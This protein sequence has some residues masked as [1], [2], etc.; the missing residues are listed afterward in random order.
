MLVL[1]LLIALVLLG[2][3]GVSQQQKAR[4]LRERFRPIEDIESYVKSARSSADSALGKARGEADRLLGSARSDA[5]RALGNAQSQAESMLGR[6]RREADELVG[7]AKRERASLND[8]IT[9]LKADAES[10]ANELALVE[11]GVRLKADDAHLLEVGYYEPIYGF[12]DLPQ[13]QREI[14]Q[15][16][17]EQRKMLRTGGEGGDHS[18]AAFASESITYNGSKAEGRKLLKKVLQLML[19]AF[20]GECDSFIARV[21][22]RNVTTMQK[23]VQSSFD[24][25]NKIG[26]TWHC[27]LSEKY[28]SNRMAELNLAYEYAELDQ[29]IKE[30][31]AAIRQQER[32]DEK[33]RREA[34]RRERDAAKKEAAAEQAVKEAQAAMEASS[35]S[36][37]AAYQQRIE[38]LE[39]QLAEAQEERQRAKS[40]AEQTR[41]GYVYVLSN[42]GSF[43]EDV[44]KIGMT[45]REDPDERRRELGDASVPFPFDYHAYI[46]TEDAP[47]LER[48]LHLHFDA[49]RLNLENQRKEFFRITIDE[50]QKEIDTLKAQLGITAEIR[51]TLL[52]EA[53]DFRKSEAKRKHL[54]ASFRN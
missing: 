2:A 27:R 39:R 1:L 21:N 16:K 45:R 40:L 14:D 34:E 10:A 32:E 38:E 4:R 44:Y 49:K 17:E 20:N 52:A 42:I 37:R 7:A 51:W 11:E 29:Q 12:E 46:W 26:A 47:A 24:Q 28:L 23:R 53:K 25:I 19:R 8:R 35:E 22:Y 36:E 48:A 5:E 18:A 54:E 9:K 50:I 43:G 31:Q 6:A 30:E 15:I 13:Y 41:A 3:W 33:A